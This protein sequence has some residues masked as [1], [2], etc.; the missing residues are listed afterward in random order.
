MDLKIV[1]KKMRG[2]CNNLIKF[3]INY[4]AGLLDI[5]SSILISVFFQTRG[6]DLSLHISTYNTEK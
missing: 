6:H 5:V 1:Q 4:P 2:V 3:Y